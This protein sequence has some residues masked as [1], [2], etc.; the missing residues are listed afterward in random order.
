MI[1]RRKLLGSTAAAGIA[2]LAPVAAM[3]AGHPDANLIRLCEEHAANVAAYNTHGGMGGSDDPDPLWDAYK[4]TRDAIYDTRP[5]TLAGVI[6]KARAAK[7]DAA[8]E[9]G[10]DCPDGTPGQD[11]AWQLVCDL[12][13]G[14]AGA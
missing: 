7:A 3:A 8:V 2:A 9:D 5:T 1:R 10:E 11:W 12:V 6:A 14:R 13:D 4:A